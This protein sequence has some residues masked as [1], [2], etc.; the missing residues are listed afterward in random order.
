MTSLE[1]IGIT[2]GAYF[3]SRQE[4]L[5]WLNDLL[6]LSLT[7]VEDI[8]T[9]AV[10]CQVFDSMYPGKV[11]MR[12]VKFDVKHEYE[13]EHNWKILTDVFVDLGIKRNIPVDRLVKARQ[14]DNLEFLQ[15]VYEYYLRMNQATQFAAYDPEKRRAVS[16]GGAT[17]SKSRTGK[18][19]PVSASKGRE[20]R[21]V[22]TAASRVAEKRLSGE[23]NEQIDIEKIVANRT[24]EL[25]KKLVYFQSLA[26]ET[27]R[28]RDFYFDKVASI[29]EIC[30]QAV[31]EC[32][33]LLEQTEND[34]LVKEA[35]MWKLEICHKIETVIYDEQ[36]V[37]R[38][39]GNNDAITDLMAKEGL[40]FGVL[41]GN[42]NQ[43]LESTNLKGDGR[44][45][46][47]NRL[48]DDVC[49]Q[50]DLRLQL[51]K[52]QNMDSTESFN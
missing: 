29:D 41:N 33:A 22:R 38:A 37:P 25:M 15:W 13:Y 18:A 11:P 39:S 42:G 48:M 7:R 31:Q 43:L 36:D 46:E 49:T 32:D 35:A 40:A 19:A 24:Q 34:D 6:H 16:R 12:K 9:G 5:Q 4:L 3:V 28:E 1:S 45:L 52:A 26:A 21:T 51:L 30:K 10:I 8:A 47:S 17:F 44:V 14:Q 2:A 27:E 23:V 50:Q 20:N